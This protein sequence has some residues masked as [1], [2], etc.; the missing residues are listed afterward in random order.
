MN[1]SSDQRTRVSV[2]GG[3]VFRVRRRR[4]PTAPRILARHVHQFRLLKNTANHELTICCTRP[5][6]RSRMAR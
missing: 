6:T 3:A 2:P 4:E 1:V 5:K